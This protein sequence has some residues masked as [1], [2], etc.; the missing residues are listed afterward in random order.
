VT[1]IVM[2][3]TVTVTVTTVSTGMTGVVVGGGYAG[4][5]HQTTGSERQGSDTRAGFLRE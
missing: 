3:V 4:C 1:I 5:H 2:T